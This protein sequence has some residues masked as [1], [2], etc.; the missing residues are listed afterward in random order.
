[1]LND[2][3]A[4]LKRKVQ[5]WKV[6]IAL[7]ELLH[8]AKRMSIMIETPAA[9]PHQLVEFAFSG[10][11]EWRMADIMYQRQGFDE[12]RIQSQRGSH[13]PRDLRNLNRMRQPVSEMVGEA[14]RENLRLGF[15]PPK[16]SRVHDAI[17]IA[18]VFTAI[19]VQRFWIA[20]ATRLTC[21]HGPRRECET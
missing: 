19:T 10:M 3:L 17:A 11:T 12:F 20:A 1:M 6:R 18:R 2:A 8:D 15:Q 13:R 4:H 21:V 5:S 14:R 9:Q 16:R 7:L